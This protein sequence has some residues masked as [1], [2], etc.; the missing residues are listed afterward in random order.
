MCHDSWFRRMRE[1]RQA[2]RELWDEFER[3]QPLSDT[4]PADKDAEVTLEHPE[5]EPV[6]TEQ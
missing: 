1:E 2:S 4:E 3:T 5:S 6:A